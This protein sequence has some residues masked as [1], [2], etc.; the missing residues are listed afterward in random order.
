MADDVYKAAFERSM[1]EVQ[2]VL[3][4]LSI[5]KKNANMLAGLAGTP[6]PFE[7]ADAPAAS[8]IGLLRPDQFANYSAPSESARA[9]LKWRGREKGAVEIGVIFEGMKRGGYTFTA[10]KSEQQ[11]GLA[12]ALG[13]D[14]LVRRLDNDTYGL[15]EWY[16]QAKRDKEKKKADVES[17]DSEPSA[18]DD[19]P[20]P[21]SA[22]GK[23]DIDPLAP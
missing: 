1:E 11:G 12:K 18:S 2:E 6:V 3:A 19:T 16:P 23:E 9:F 13:K 5:K 17:P 22:E 8:S 21:P 10:A 4:T 14:K 15:W 7:D 20:E